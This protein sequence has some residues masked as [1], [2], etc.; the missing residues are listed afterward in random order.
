VTC[1]VTTMN[2]PAICFVTFVAFSALSAL[3]LL[4]K[5]S[6]FARPTKE[7]VAFGEWAKAL[8]DTQKT[9]EGM[10]RFER[11]GWFFKE[12]PKREG[13]IIKKYKVDVWQ[14]YEEM[15]KGIEQNWPTEKPE[16]R[17][18]AATAL[19]HLFGF[20]LTN[21][22]TLRSLA[23]DSSER[24]ITRPNRESPHSESPRR[25]FGP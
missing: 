16:H 22:T 14:F 19:S 21:R 10:G 1:Y 3:L 7:Q 12:W 15:A 25:S 9:A 6:S 13:R 4:V 11:G 20:P 17:K 2:K 8:Y 23:R 5:P 18:A 24:P